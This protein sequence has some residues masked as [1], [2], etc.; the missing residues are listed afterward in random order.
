MKKMSQFYEDLAEMANSIILLMSPTGVIQYINKYGSEFFGFERD[1][2]VGSNI[3]GT[4]VPETDSSGHKLSR[5]EGCLQGSR[6][7]YQ[8]RQ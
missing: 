7:A 4:I 6:S 5:H 2:L 3:I 8:E 1:A